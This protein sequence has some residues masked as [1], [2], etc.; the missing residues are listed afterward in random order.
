MEDFNGPRHCPNGLPVKCILANG[1]G[2][3]CEGGDHPTYLFPVSVDGENHPEDEANEFYE[4]PQTHALIYTDGSVALTLY[5][6][7]YTLWSLRTGTGLGGRYQDES[8]RLSEEIRAKIE[9]YLVSL[10]RN[11]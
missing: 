11:G 6:C 10:E 1:I 7:N 8:D 3:E 5:E 9:S 2:L 4:Y